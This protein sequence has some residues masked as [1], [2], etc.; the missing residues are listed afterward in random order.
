VQAALLP[1]VALLLLLSAHRLRVCVLHTRSLPRCRAATARPAATTSSLLAV[2]CGVAGGGLWRCVRPTTVLWH[3]ECWRGG[4]AQI[5]RDLWRGG[6]PL[7]VDGGGRVCRCLRWCI[8]DR[9][10]ASPPPDTCRC[11][12]KGAPDC[13][14]CRCERSVTRVRLWCWRA[15]SVTYGLNV[16]HDCCTPLQ[17]PSTPAAPPHPSIL[18][19]QTPTRAHASTAQQAPGGCAAPLT[20][21]CVAGC[22][23]ATATRHQCADSPPS[24]AGGRGWPRAPRGAMARARAPRMPQPASC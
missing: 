7:S 14:S 8:G 11:H 20:A 13:V 16:A 1:L 6:T 3:R 17:T 19:L 15:Q 2:W 23:G 5:T 4:R 24:H 22:G 10:G 21:S 18:A 9:D 12:G